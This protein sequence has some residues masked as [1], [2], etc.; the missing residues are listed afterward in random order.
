MAIFTGQPGALSAGGTGQWRG[1]PRTNIRWRKQQAGGWRGGAAGT[2]EAAAAAGGQQ[3]PK[4]G[5]GWGGWSG[6]QGAG[7]FQAPTTRLAG[8]K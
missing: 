5:A 2:A 7:N 1:N 8:M 4:W 6:G 3:A